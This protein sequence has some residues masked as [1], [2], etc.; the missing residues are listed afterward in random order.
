MHT[1]RHLYIHYPVCAKV[2]PY[3]SF[4]VHTSSTGAQKKLV[5]ALCRELEL[6]QKEYV[7]E[8]ETIYFGGGTPSILPAALFTQLAAALPAHR[9]GEITIE[10]NP[11]TVTQAKTSA[12]KSAGINRVSLGAQSF[13]AG[14]LKLLGR[15]HKPEDIARTVAALRTHGFGNINIDL[16]YALPS[17]RPELWQDTLKASLD[18]GPEHISAYALTYEEDTPFFRKRLSGE[19]VPDEERETRMFE[20]TV[21]LLTK[22][23]LPP[24]EISNFARPGFESAHNRAYWQGKDYLG[25]GPSAVST[26][27]G[28]RWKNV[29][30]SAR[31][32]ASLSA[33]RIERV[34]KEELTP[35]IRRRERILLELRTREGVAASEIK[36][37]TLKTLEQDKL[38]TR[39]GDRVVLTPRGRLVADSVAL[40]LF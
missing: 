14:Y 5:D 28:K 29:P 3:C 20:E 37:E 26:V 13:D 33:G 39:R 23:G 30:D 18:C 27:G 8:L 38:L 11:A 36:Q 16:M 10:V 24:Y 21:D 34:E 9:A 2:C 32:M 1:I 17:Q 25:I 6:A 22:A 15:Q 7:F 35:E 4:Y 31:Y 40:S 19:F 12:W